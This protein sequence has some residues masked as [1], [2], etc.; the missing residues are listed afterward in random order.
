M[1]KI[2]ITGFMAAGKTTVARA[3]ARRLSAAFVDLYEL[4]V[5]REGRTVPELIEEE[6]EARF[7]EAEAGALLE[8]L[9]TEAEHGVVIALGGGAWTVE[10]N[11]ALIAEHGATTVWLDAPFELCWQRIMLGAQDA[12]A[13]VRPLAR[14][15]E[16]AL[17]LYD[18]RQTCY[19]LAH[20]RVPAD[21][22]RTADDLAHEIIR[23]GSEGR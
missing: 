13:T 17:A 11:R 12:S 8:A 3:L 10:R 15:R 22:A 23:R 1:R 7:R 5:A 20:L 18:A 21:A 9:R 4:I 2:V 16:Q 14:S 19:G 6:G